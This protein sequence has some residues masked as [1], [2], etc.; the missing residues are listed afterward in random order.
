[1]S[2]RF[3]IYVDRQQGKISQSSIAKGSIVAPS[4]HTHLENVS[5]FEPPERGNPRSV[6]TH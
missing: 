3:G 6:V 4:P 5:D 1:M 2:V